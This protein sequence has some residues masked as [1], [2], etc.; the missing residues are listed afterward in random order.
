MR[1]KTLA[2]AALLGVSALGLSGCATGFPAKVSRYQAMPAPQGQSFF[3]VPANP[4][5][6]GK[7][8]FSRY[9]GL[10][11]QAMRAHGYAQAATPEQATMVVKL[12]YG[13]DEGK[14]EVVRDPFARG[15]YGRDPF[16]GGYYDPF[17]RSRFGRPYYSRFGYWG[18]RSPFYYGWNDPYWYMDD[19]YGQVR[20]YTVYN[21]WLDVDIV[22]RADN[23][24]LFEGM[25]QARSRTDELG[26]LVPNLVEAMFTGFPGRSGESV[27]ITVPPARKGS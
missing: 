6:A 15:F 3:L 21:S 27:K 23:A 8:E 24:S 10:V 20:V 5:D 4:A 19:P 7:L 2:A 18:P 14:Q 12:A 13:V 22:R 16:Y 1:I 9:A 25:A 11:D 26:V 17:Y